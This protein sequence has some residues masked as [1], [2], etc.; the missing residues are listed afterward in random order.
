MKL[1]KH[2]K[3]KIMHGILTFHSETGTEGGWYCFVDS[4]GM[5][6]NT[7]FFT[8]TKCNLFWHKKDGDPNQ[9][10]HTELEDNNLEVNNNGPLCEWGSHDFKAKPE[11]SW[12]YDHLHYLKNGDR[13]TVY[14]KED[15]NIV[16]F[17]GKVQL[18]SVEHFTYTI[19]GYWVNQKPAE[20]MGVREHSWALWFFQ[21]YEAVLVRPE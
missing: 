14:N 4:A 6:P 17:S 9:L 3:T 2:P 7:E 12:S 13:L 19:F 15:K 16:L 5:Y 18:E 1:L 11:L 10:N 21:E 20:A 8:C